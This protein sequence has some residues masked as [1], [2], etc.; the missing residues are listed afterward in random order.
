MHKVFPRGTTP[1]FTQQLNLTWHGMT[2][3]RQVPPNVGSLNSMDVFVCICTVV[4][5]DWVGNNDEAV[6]FWVGRH[7][8]LSLQ[9]HGA[10]VWVRFYH[11][12]RWVARSGRTWSGGRPTGPHSVKCCGASTK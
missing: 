8:P 3:R 5:D 1:H 2:R 10:K 6:F 7:A 4:T 11:A 9:E 12:N